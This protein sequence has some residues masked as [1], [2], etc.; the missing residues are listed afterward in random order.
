[1][2]YPPS[3]IFKKLIELELDRERTQFLQ[4]LQSPTYNISYQY[5]NFIKSIYDHGQATGKR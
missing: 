2:F 5:L 3:T 1:M 4:N